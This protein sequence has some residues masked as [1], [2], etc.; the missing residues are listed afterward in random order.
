MRKMTLGRI[1][2]FLILCLIPATQIFAR[3]TDQAPEDF[4]R[5]AFDGDVPK[6]SVLWITASLKPGIREILGH[7]LRV[8]RM[9]YWGHGTRTAWI[10][11]EIGKEKPITTGVV[12]DR[13]KIEL[14]KVLIYRESRGWEVRHPFFTD[15]F[16]GANLKKGEQLDR[17]IDGVSGAT[18]SVRALTKL[19]R[20]GL[21]LHQHSEFANVSG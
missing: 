19:A 7:D 12:V 2:S 17:P 18:L 10:L 8:L 1:L 20:L 15:Q 11:E 5:E 13:G 14:I 21:Y 4:I 3:G 6:Q 9:R 16:K